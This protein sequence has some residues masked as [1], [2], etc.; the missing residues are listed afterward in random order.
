MR[1]VV[2]VRRGKPG[3]VRVRLDDGRTLAV[4]EDFWRELGVAAPGP[5]DA[6]TLHRLERAEQ[7]ARLQRRALRLLAVRPRSA[8]ELRGRLS[9][10]GDPQ[11]AEEVVADLQRRGLVDDRQ[12]AREWV[13]ARR[14]ARGFGA[15]R[16]RGEL[17]R[18]GVPRE[19]VEEALQQ[20]GEDDRHLAVEAA[21]ARMGRYQHLPPEV[22][23]RRLAGYL[24]RRGFGPAEVLEALRAV[25]LR[26]GSPAHEEAR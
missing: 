11:L 19:H 1:Q 10:A 4:P 24:A 13:R 25:G 8:R 6:G 12:F 2:A 7:R 3:E 15:A 18:K 20:A 23:A 16:L 26:P 21:R 22:A 17:L 14:R 9:R 5:V